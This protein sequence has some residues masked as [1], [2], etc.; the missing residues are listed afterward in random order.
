MMFTIR[1]IRVLLVIGIFLA[2]PISSKAAGFR[3]FPPGPFLSASVSYNAVTKT[4]TLTVDPQR[5]ESFQLD[6]A[7]DPNRAM[8]TGS[9]FVSP[10]MPTMSPN[11][12]QLSSGRLLDVAGSSSFPPPGEVDIFSVTFADLNPNLPFS[13]AVFTVFASSNDF[14][15]F[16]DPE[17]GERTTFRGDAIPAVS[18]SVPEPATLLLLGT[19][20]AGIGLKMRRK[21]KERKSG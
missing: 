9:S 11:F 3:L 4:W 17:T 5:L 15:T 14:L 8:F 18:G 16:V 19:G 10:Y 21:L 6:I 2:T 1:F 13:D 12:S 7:F 20:L